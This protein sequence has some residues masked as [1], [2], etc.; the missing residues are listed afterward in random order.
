MVQY[1]S[2]VQKICYRR[3]RIAFNG[4]NSKIKLEVFDEK[5]PDDARVHV[6]T[7]RNDDFLAVWN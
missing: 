4:I 2:L 7:R 6:K 3:V 1:Y 5:Y